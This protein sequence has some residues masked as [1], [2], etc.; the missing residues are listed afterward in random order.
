MTLLLEGEFRIKNIEFRICFFHRFKSFQTASWFSGNKNREPFCFI[1]MTYSRRNFLSCIVAGTVLLPRFVLSAPNLRAGEIDGKLAQ[2]GDFPLASAVARF[3]ERQKLE[4][5]F[6]PT[7][8]DKREYLRLADGI[9]R[10]F[11]AYQDARGAIIDPFEKRERQYSTPAFACASAVLYASGYNR[12]LLPVCVKAMDAAINDLVAGKSADNHSNFYTVM[13]MQAYE[14]LQ[15]S[16]PKT[17][18]MRWRENL[19][20]LV[21]EKIYR[22]KPQSETNWNLVAASGE[23]RRARAGMSSDLTWMQTALDAQMKLWT[24]YGMYRD[25]NDPLAY[26]HFARYYVEDLLMNGYAG[27]HAALLRELVDRAAWTSLFMQSPHGELPCG[28]RSAHHQWNEAEQAMT[29]EYYAAEFAKKGDKGAAGAFKRAARLSVRSVGRWQKP[30]GELWIVKNRFDSELRYGYDSYSFHSQ[31]NLLTAAKL[32]NAF[33][34]A[35]DRIKEL[36]SPAETGGFVFALQPAFHKV[37]ANAGGMY[38]EIETRADSSYNPTGLLRVHRAGVNPQLTVSDGVTLNPAYKTPKLP[39]RALAIGP[40]WRDRNGDWHSLAEH[41][42]KVLRDADL[43]VTG[44]NSAARL[45]FE[46]KYN[47]NFRGGAT[48][49]RQKF[50]V[51][52]EQVEVTDIIEGDVGGARA[53]LPLFLSDGQNETTVE[54]TGNHASATLKNGDAQTYKVLS[55]NIKL[56]RL[57]VAEPFR[58]GTLDAAY[59]ETRGKS[60][61][62]LIQ[63]RTARKDRRGED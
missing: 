10:Y 37:F 11:A 36:P 60:I 13:L 8:L 26:D 61:T 9:V 50:T 19:S 59:A 57:G 41:D 3:R 45:E 51:T 38:L 54:V 62:Y 35:D 27:Q 30:S 42:R 24:E 43:K 7:K 21:P 20:R 6:V 25:P 32:C 4:K 2:I 47:G 14:I 18:L 58:N 63:P 5:N 48:S 53:Y 16:V 12:E 33:L 28:G 46:V 40:A 39:T 15:K 52:P 55:D 56:E 34:R 31:Y 23:W 29:Y 44:E 49:V 17:D 1:K 22:F